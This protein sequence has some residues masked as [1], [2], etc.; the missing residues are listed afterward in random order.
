MSIQNIQ[1]KATN[2]EMKPEWQE[3]LEVK[4]SSLDKYL[5]DQSSVRCEIE[6]E[7]AAQ[8]KSGNVHRVEANL[9]VAGA[10]YRADA[11]EASFEIAIDEVRAE[12]DKEL[13]RARTKKE[14]LYRKGKRAIKNMMQR[15]E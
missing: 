13:R 6:F 12:L 14:S 7:K 8:Q 3:L 1:Y 5:G 9:I 10:L 15:G 4:F 2:V 11:T